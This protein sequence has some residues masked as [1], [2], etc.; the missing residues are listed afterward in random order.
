MIAPV[1]QSPSVRV[2]HPSLVGMARAEDR[3]YSRVGYL[4]HNVDRS[5]L[6]PGDHIYVY[7][8]TWT[9]SHHGIYVGEH[10]CDVIHFT[11]TSDAGCSFVLSKAMSHHDSKLTGPKSSARVQK[12]LLED[13]CDGSEVHLAAYGCPTLTM[14]LKRSGTCYVQKSRPA[15][16]VIARAKYFLEKPNEWPLYNIEHNNCSHFAYYCKTEKRL[17]SGGI[18]LWRTLNPVSKVWGDVVHG[19]SANLDT[20]NE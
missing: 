13:F 4:F 11:G 17:V 8:R 10:D 1:F 2:F 12:T 20:N 5:S 18:S 19:M 7:R 9:Y 3:S 16:E 14:V 15:D 6:A